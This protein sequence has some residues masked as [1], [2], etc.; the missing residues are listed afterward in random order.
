MEENAAREA[1]SPFAAES[2][3]HPGP[4]GDFADQKRLYDEIVA[5]HENELSVSFGRVRN[6]VDDVMTEAQAR[7]WFEYPETTKKDFE[8]KDAS[9]L[10]GYPDGCCLMIVEKTLGIFH[11]ILDEEAPYLVDFIEKGGVVAKRWG[12]YK[13]VDGREYLQNFIQVGDRI[14]DVAYEEMEPGEMRKV[15][16]SRISE[17]RYRNFETLPEMISATEKYYAGTRHYPSPNLIGWIGI[18]HSNLVFHEETGYLMSAGRNLYF[19]FDEVEKYLRGTPDFGH[20]E[21]VERRMLTAVAD[22]LAF[23]RESLTEVEKFM[24]EEIAFHLQRPFEKRVNLDKQIV[25]AR[26]FFKHQAGRLGISVEEAFEELS[27]IVDC[28]MARVSDEYYDRLHEERAASG[29]VD[30]KRA[31]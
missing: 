18:F 13:T 6:F 16:V 19:G 5:P 1:Y 31:E 10:F 20:D 7:L 15:S 30:A 3:L 26:N 29:L 9:P 22:I 2:R 17:G 28:V 25:H 11:W 23:E 4:T 14:W 12:G 21:N 27:H 8:N 24:L